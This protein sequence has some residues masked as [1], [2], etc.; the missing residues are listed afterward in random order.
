[1]LLIRFVV[2]AIVDSELFFALAFLSIRQFIARW[3][4]M[5]CV[6][7]CLFN[8]TPDNTVRRIQREKIVDGV[9]KMKRSALTTRFKRDKVDISI[10]LNAILNKFFFYLSLS[11]CLFV[12]YYSLVFMQN[13]CH[14]FTFG[15]CVFFFTAATAVAISTSRLPYSMHHIALCGQALLIIHVCIHTHTWFVNVYYALYV[16]RIHLQLFLLQVK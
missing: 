3:W 4:K 8:A 12:F 15:V 9:A 2:D 10:H 11:F 5:T 16:F 13:F 7:S 1:M 6:F 14:Y